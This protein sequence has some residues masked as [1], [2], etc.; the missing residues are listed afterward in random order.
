MKKK[1]SCREIDNIKFT[2]VYKDSI[3]RVF[4]MYKKPIHFEQIH[5]PFMTKLKILEGNLLNEVGTTFQFFW[6]NEVKIESVV[7][8]VIEESYF[9]QIKF[10]FF[11]VEPTDFKY[12]MIYKMRWIHTDEVTLFTHI[13]EFGT[14][15][16]LTFY[17]LQADHEEKV[18][19]F[20]KA[21]LYLQSLTHLLIHEESVVINTSLDN[22]WDI[23]TDMEK[24]S[25][26]APLVA[27]RFEMDHEV[28]KIYKDNSEVN[29]I[30]VK[31]M[32]NLDNSEYVV[33]V[34]NG[35]PQTQLKELKF[36]LVSLGCVKSLLIFT[37]IFYE[38]IPVLSFKELSATKQKILTSLRRNI[39]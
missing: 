24:F 7:E 30:E 26:Y 17:Q 1:Q 6:K 21:A 14:L 39:K 12:H 35:N 2:Y 16:S 23:I 36:N 32:L 13:C 10:Y 20:S 37:H 38:P 28:M 33:R 18:M 3:D 8:E 34:L 22:L 29:C 31:K 9:K 5:S 4:E 15:Q 19:L 11:K 27:D 25:H